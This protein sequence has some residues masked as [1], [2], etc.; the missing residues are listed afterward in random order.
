M[1]LPQLGAEV[2]GVAGLSWET[3]VDEEEKKPAL[4]LHHPCACPWSTGRMG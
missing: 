1:I 4:R 3:T 2:H